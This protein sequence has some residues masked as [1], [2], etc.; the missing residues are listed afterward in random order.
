MKD[1]NYF[2]RHQ[3]KEDQSKKNKMTTRQTL[4]RDELQKTR[5]ELI[6]HDM[7]EKMLYS[8]ENRLNSDELKWVEDNIYGKQIEDVISESKIIQKDLLI[9]LETLKDMRDGK[10][11]INTPENKL[12]VESAP[13]VKVNK[14]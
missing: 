14:K 4:I 11:N 9:R 6:G 3:D 12:F 10:P 1:Q 5:E 8:I 7:E 13:E 2:E